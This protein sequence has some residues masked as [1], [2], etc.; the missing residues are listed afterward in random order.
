MNVN[1]VSK[2]DNKGKGKV[3]HSDGY[4]SVKVYDLKPATTYTFTVTGN[5]GTP[6]SKIV[7]KDIVFTTYPEKV[8]PKITKTE[9]LNVTETSA[10][11][12]ATVDI[13][14]LDETNVIFKDEKDSSKFRILRIT[15][16]QLT[17]T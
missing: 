10:T 9:A 8:Q 7:G 4:M 6:E 2:E 3:V 16:E 13:G 5:N 14:T 1:F 17:V 12:S 15:P 11:L